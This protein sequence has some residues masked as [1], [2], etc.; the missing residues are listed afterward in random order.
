MPSIYDRAFQGKYRS[1]DIKFLKVDPK[2]K[3]IYYKWINN[4]PHANDSSRRID[5]PF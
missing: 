3:T 5:I 2:S 1:H 4:T